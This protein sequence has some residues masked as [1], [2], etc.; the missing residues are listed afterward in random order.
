[1]DGGDRRQVDAIDGPQQVQQDLELVL[2]AAPVLDQ[3]RQGAVAEP[4]LLAC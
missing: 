2:G 1:M 4:V 3:L